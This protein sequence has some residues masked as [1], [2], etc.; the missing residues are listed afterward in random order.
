MSLYGQDAQMLPKPKYQYITDEE[1]AR[2]AME[3]LSKFPVHQVDV[4]ATA[5][6]PYE[7]QWSLIQIGA[8]GMSYV[9]DVRHDTE[10]SSLHPEVLDPLLLDPNIVKILQNANYDMKIIKRNRGYYIPNVYDTMLV[11]QLLNLGRGFVRAS[12]A[13]LVERYLGLQVDKE[14]RNTFEKYDQKFEPYQIEYA[15]NDVTPLELI[16]DMQWEKVKKEKL[17]NACR[18]EFEFLVPLCE[19]EMNGI[20]ID[21]DKWNTIMKDVDVERREVKG[22]VQ[23][24]LAETDDQ[25]TLFGV[26][27]VNIDSHAQLKSALRK[28]GMNIE[29]T[30]AGELAKFSGVPVIDAI[31]DYR[32]ASKL[33]ST[34]AQ[35]LLDKISPVTGRLHTDFRQM[36]STGRM[37]S[38]NPNLQNIPGKQK[39]RSCFIAPEGYSLLT[40]DMSGAELRILGNLSKDPVFIE[41]YATGQDLHTRTA[42]EMFNVPYEEAKQKKYRGAAKAINFGLCYGMSA[43]GLSKRLN[44]T[45]M[46]AKQLI[47]AYFKAYKGVKRFLDKAGKD[48]VRNRYSTTVSGRRRY[49]NMPPYDHPDR[50]KIQRS[51]E[52][53]GKN[54]GIQGANA[55]TIKE[56]MILLVERLKPYDARLILTVHDEVVVEAHDSQR[57]EVAEVVS[58]CL[59][60]GF[61]RYFSTIPMKSD[62]LVGPCWLKGECEDTSV[63]GKLMPGCGGTHMKFIPS[64]KYGTKLVCANCGK[65]QD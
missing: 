25:T 52:R 54:A 24:L 17:E 19:M 65:E 40:A 58:Q 63:E 9:F 32:K 41:A 4:E 62:T 31:L 28:T 56:S 1:S 60:D 22:I 55:D 38:S 2:R 51:V 7:A 39:F 48:A 59:V 53:K 43:V 8:G 29:S 45:E 61:G 64:P 44:I 26:S 50:N 35:S 12:F 5:L 47:T 37:S 13:A 20:K 6:D 3:K 15:A 23:D 27:L 42:S 46:E 36:V 21:V 10:Y 34:Y 16:R 11:E 18:L 30:A 49:Y 14:P 57:E 33:I